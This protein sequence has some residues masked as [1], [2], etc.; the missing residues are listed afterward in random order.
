M[1]IGGHFEGQESYLPCIL[2]VG[3]GC[4]GVQV[5]LLRKRQFKIS[6]YVIS[7]NTNFV[8]STCTFLSLIFNVLIKH[9]HIRED[10]SG[11]LKLQMSSFHH[12]HHRQSSAMFYKPHLFPAVYKI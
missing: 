6:V 4:S 12:Y 1:Y 3:S 11:L 7:S 10:K 2:P 5:L 8:V 9:D